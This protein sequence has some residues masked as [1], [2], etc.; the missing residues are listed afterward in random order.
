MILKQG[1][2]R[3]V[4]CGCSKSQFTKVVVNTKSKKKNEKLNS[5]I[6]WLAGISLV[7]AFAYGYFFN[8]PDFTEIISGQLNKSEIEHVSAGEYRIKTQ[9]DDQLA[10]DYVPVGQES[11]YGGPL[12][13]G[14]V[15]DQKG[16]IKNILI[17]DHKETQSFINKLKV[18]N[19]FTQFEGKHIQDPILIHQDI[20]AVNGATISSVAIANAI[21]NSSHLVGSKYFSI[22]YQSEKIKWELTKK[23]FIAFGIL[24]LAIL[25]TYL[26]MKWLR[27]LTLGISL[28]FLGFYFNAAVNVAH[29][30]RLLLGFLPSFMENIYWYIL[31]GGSVIFPFFFKK[32]IYCNTMCPFHAVQ[33]IMIRIGGM[34]IKFSPAIQKVAKHSSKFLLWLAL[35]IILISRN[36]TLASYEPFAMIFGLEGDGMQWYILPFVLI[37]VLLIRDYFCRYF[38]PVGQGFK[39]LMKFRKWIDSFHHYPKTSNLKKTIS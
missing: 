15:I 24:V 31:L 16:I 14:P 18:N 25:A 30:G 8:Q 4:R 13:I 28:V 10:I 9:R 27:Y 3:N 19:F 34:K 33:T 39:Y 21:R 37:G 6:S 1:V 20:D 5:L 32:N 2:G 35:I 36:P 38:C 22:A 17:I 23:D 7:A 26:R 12:S 11:G 29:F